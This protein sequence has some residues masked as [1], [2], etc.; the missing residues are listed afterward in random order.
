MAEGLSR[1]APAAVREPALFETHPS[2]P[3]RV[4]AILLLLGA[5]IL[6]VSLGWITYGEREARQVARDEPAVPAENA[7]DTPINPLAWVRWLFWTA[8][9]ALAFLLALTVFLRWSHHFRRGLLRR[10]APPTEYSDAWAMHQTPPA[11]DD[12]SQP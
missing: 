12:E 10:P 2:G 5:A 6:I 9:L 1:R 8:I 7:A 4:A 3:P 11:E